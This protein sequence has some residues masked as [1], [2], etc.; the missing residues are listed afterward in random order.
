MSDR[1]L[2]GIHGNDDSHGKRKSG[3]GLFALIGFGVV[4]VIVVAMIIIGGLS[5]GSGNEK[6]RA[7]VACENQVKSMLKAPSTARMSSGATGSD[8]DYT[9]A[10][11][12]DAQNSFGA[13]I[14]NTYTCVVAIRGDAAAVKITQWD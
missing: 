10:G 4:A 6:A 3:C 7:V 12:V 2:P 1:S 8:G 13:T 11:Q 5:N 14:R 9:V